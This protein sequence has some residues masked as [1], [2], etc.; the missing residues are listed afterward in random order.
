MAA[1]KIAP[2]I[3]VGNTV[4]IHPSSS[5]PLSLLE[6]A[7]LLEQVLS[8]GVVSIITGGGS[9]SKKLYAGA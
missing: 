3:V 4:V 1:W 6:L 7:K 8:A 2:A 5:T 9:D